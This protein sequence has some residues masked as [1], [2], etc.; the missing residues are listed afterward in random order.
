MEIV[1]KLQSEK[2]PPV[3]SKKVK[4][5]E[6]T[7]HAPSEK[8]TTKVSLGDGGVSFLGKHPIH[9]QAQYCYQEAGRGVSPGRSFV[10]IQGQNYQ[11]EH[12]ILT[13]I[14]SLI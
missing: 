12:K 10:K 4:P 2:V 6:E 14:K 9:I 8:R 1:F 7:A 11:L 13:S 5:G 3:R